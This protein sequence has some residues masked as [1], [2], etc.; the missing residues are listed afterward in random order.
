MNENFKYNPDY[1]LSCKY[2]KN[3]YS[4]NLVNQKDKTTQGQTIH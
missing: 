2:I 4:T 3:I 1:S